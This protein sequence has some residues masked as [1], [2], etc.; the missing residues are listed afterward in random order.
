MLQWPVVQ[1]WGESPRCQVSLLY[2]FPPFDKVGELVVWGSVNNVTYPALFSSQPTGWSLP[3]LSSTMTVLPSNNKL[4]D[5]VCTFISG[6]TN[7][8]P[9]YLQ[10]WPCQHPIKDNFAILVHPH[11]FH[12]DSITIQWKQDNCLCIFILLSR[13]AI[14]FLICFPP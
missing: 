9:A 6:P 8:C 7:I 2:I 4:Y 13:H 14:I 11:V 3:N 12:H 10:L 5:C 1:I